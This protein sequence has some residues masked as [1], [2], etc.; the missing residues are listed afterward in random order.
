MAGVTRHPAAAWRGLV[1]LLG[2]AV[3]GFGVAYGV[4]AGRQGALSAGS[5]RTR[6]APRPR[7]RTGT[8]TKGVVKPAYFEERNRQ[9]KAGFLGQEAILPTV[10]S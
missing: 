5:P 8:S 1:L 10:R 4:A 6:T 3:T 9:W 7:R 2:L